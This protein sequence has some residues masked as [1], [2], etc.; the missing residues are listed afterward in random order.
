MYANCKYILGFL[1]SRLKA[2]PIKCVSKISVYNFLFD[3]NASAYVTSWLR[4]Y[5][6]VILRL[7]TIAYGKLE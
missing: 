2:N 3:Y 7:G 6:T 5:P 4:T 1:L